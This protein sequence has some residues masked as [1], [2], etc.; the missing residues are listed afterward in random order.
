MKRTALVRRTPL[1]SRRPTP[2]THKLLVIRLRGAALLR[3][4]WQC[5]IRDLKHCVACGC[6][7]FWQ[8]RFDGDQAAYEMAHVRGRGASGSDVLENVR[9]LCSACHREEH[10]V[11]SRFGL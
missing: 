9:V 10:G 6:L 3:L 4:R 5:W 1:R 8:A 7:T 2:R 11:A